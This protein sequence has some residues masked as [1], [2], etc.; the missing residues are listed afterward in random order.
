MRKCKIVSPVYHYVKTL[1]I[2]KS[3]YFLRKNIYAEH[4]KK[5]KFFA[6]RNYAVFLCH[7][8]HT[9]YSCLYA[10]KKYRLYEMF[11]LLKKVD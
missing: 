11:M 4:F 6:L 9:K 3:T 10:L 8:S 7:I 1:E 2:L 5:Y